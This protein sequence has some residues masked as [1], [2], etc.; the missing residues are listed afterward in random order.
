MAGSGAIENEERHG[1][2]PDP[3]IELLFHEPM[4]GWH[5]PRAESRADFQR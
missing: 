3:F 2:L 1:T 4:L 5:K